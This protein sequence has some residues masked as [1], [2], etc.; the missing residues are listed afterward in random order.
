MANDFTK[1]FLSIAETLAP[2]AEGAMLTFVAVR[3]GE[4]FMLIDGQLLLGTDQVPKACFQSPSV[5]AGQYRISD[6]GK[7]VSQVLE[8]VEAGSLKLPNVE[9]FIQGYEGAGCRWG[10]DPCHPAG[11]QSRL[12]VLTVLGRE[13]EALMDVKIVD[14]ELRAAAPSFETLI[15]LRNDDGLLY[16]GGSVRFE[17]AA[18]TIIAVDTDL[19]VDGE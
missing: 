2:A 17:A 5:C 4:Q 1:Q 15:E 7:S 8:E 6:L 3:R 16:A 13:R 11:A 19:T 12:E 14:W 18:P 9:I 10:Y